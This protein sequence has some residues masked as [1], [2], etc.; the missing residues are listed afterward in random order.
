MS[1][2]LVASLE[3]KAGRTTITA[4]LGVLLAR[5]GMTVQLGRLNVHDSDSGAADDAQTLAGVPG[6]N[7]SG[8][9]LTE[10]EALTVAR[11]SGEGVVVLEAPAGNPRELAEKLGAKVVIVTPT[12]EDLVLGDLTSTVASLGDACVGLVAVRQQKR[13]LEAARGAIEGRGLTCLGVVPEDRLL[14]G[15]SARELA[16]ALHASFLVDSEGSDEAV[17]FVMLGPVSADPGQPYFLQHG[18]KAV[19]NR[20]DKMDLHL[21]AL[22]TEPECLILTGGQQPSPYLMDRLSSETSVTVLLAPEGTVRTID[23]VDELYGETRFS[24]QRKISRAAELLSQHLDS[25]ALKSALS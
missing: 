3:P 15:P 25:A 24:G 6:C 23:A 21:A 11:A 4:A 9:A 10:Q 14:A 22:A 19:V 16:E 18:A 17:E 2:I 5:E 7:A 12:I 20:F 1:T 8:Q 13:A